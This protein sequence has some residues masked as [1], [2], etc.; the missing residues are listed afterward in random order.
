MQRKVRNS[1]H[2][3]PYGGENKNRNPSEIA[4][5]GKCVNPIPL[6]FTIDVSSRR[7]MERYHT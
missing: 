7:I 3:Y 2:P 6:F 1:G 5:S 4:T